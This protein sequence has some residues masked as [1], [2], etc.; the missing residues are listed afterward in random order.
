MIAL[1]IMTVGILALLSALNMSLRASIGAAR[2]QEATEIAVNQLEIGT[3]RSVGQLTPLQGTNN[4]FQW[5]VVYEQRSQ[6][7][8]H[9]TALVRWA[10]RGEAREY[11]LSELFRP[12][13]LVER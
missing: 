8:V 3:S 13:E 11:R 9:A 10:E 2:L 12:A 4:A 5:S 1:A 6:G 7:L